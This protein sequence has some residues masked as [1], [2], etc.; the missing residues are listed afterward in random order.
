MKEFAF[1]R[2]Q[3]THR[4]LP[5]CV[6]ASRSANTVAHVQQAEIGQIRR[7]AM[8]QSKLTIGPRGDVYEQEADRAAD[9]VMRMPDNDGAKQVPEEL[10]ERTVQLQADVDTTSSGIKPEIETSLHDLQGRG[11]PLPSVERA[12]FESRFG[13]D[14]SQVR[15]HTDAQNA[16]MA[17]AL[18]ALA[19]TLGEHIVFAPGQYGPESRTG[20]V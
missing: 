15:V 11:E 14:F 7:G 6:A 20:R 4:S 5:R 17:R 18:N 13:R 2:R 8:V 1:E 16:E 3:A 9:E 12:F 10:L 19:F